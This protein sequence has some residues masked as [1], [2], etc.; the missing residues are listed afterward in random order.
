MANSF[1]SLAIDHG[2]TNSCIATMSAAGPRVLPVDGGNVTLPSTVYYDASGG[3]KVGLPARKAMMLS[4]PHAGQGFGRYKLHIGSDRKYEFTAAGK[5]LSAP[6]LG[7]I[8]IQTLLRAHQQQTGADP[9]ACVITVPAKFKQNAVEGTRA[10]AAM[11]GLKYYPLLMEPVAAAMA[12]G[13]VAASERSQWLVFDLGGGTLDV[14][15]LITRRGR[16][17]VPDGGHA[18]DDSLGGSKFDEELAGHVLAAVEKRHPLSGFRQNRTSHAWGRL[19]LA[20]EEAKIQLSDAPDARVIVD[21]LCRDD[22]GQNVNVDVTVTRRAYE[23]LIRA[24][25]ERAVQICR[26]LLKNNRLETG[27]IDKLILVGGPSKTPFVR[28]VLRERLGIPL[29]FSIDPMTAVAEG[30]AIYAGTVE[31]PQELRSKAATAAGGH[32]LKIEAEPHSSSP[33]YCAVGFV[34]GPAVEGWQVEVERL[35]GLWKTMVPVDPS[36]LFPFEVLLVAGSRPTLS[37]FK[38]TLLDG[39][40]RVLATEDAPQIWH[41]YPVVANRLANSLRVAIKGGRTEPLIEKGTELPAEESRDF[42]TTKTLRKGTTEDVLRIAVL[43]SVTDLLGREDEDAGSCLHVGTL[44]IAGSDHRVTMDIPEGADISVTL[45][46][47][48]SRRIT[49]IAS[50]EMLGQDFETAFVGESFQYDLDDLQKRTD[51]VRDALAE[52]TTLQTER[53]LPEVAEVLEALARTGVVAGLA[54]DLE[55]ARGGNKD[56]EVRGYKRLVEAEATI[57][58]LRRLQRRAR[59]EAAVDTLSGAVQGQESETLAEIKREYDRAKS[60]DDIARCLASVEQ[61][62]IAARQRPWF[63]L[64]LDVMALS[65]RQ[66][67][68][69]QNALFN[70]AAAML[71]QMGENG[72]LKKVTDADIAAMRAMHVTLVDGHPELYEWRQQKLEEFGVDNPADIATS[73]IDVARA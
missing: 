29:E 2:T 6:E 49:V 36:G 56:A 13:F 63:E 52:I 32:S 25:V 4:M 16:M 11:A 72:T 61:L 64:Q 5:S 69:Q 59:I 50:L 8:V 40:G 47:D 66:V 24:D 20:V 46:V 23:Q 38:T 55:R 18:G 45:K 60:P 57:R 70:Q 17:V 21:E 12:Y 35:D 26:M 71:D 54:A 65:G 42:V 1:V 14:S 58:E 15:L 30:A 27:A 44:V 33:T 7:A 68:S 3:L 28:D 43:E 34:D 51:A 67:S 48:E 31:L 22:R 53:P 10:A 73:D 41:P 9:R 19:L 62:E 39:T 37:Q